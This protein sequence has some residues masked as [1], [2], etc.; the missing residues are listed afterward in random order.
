MALKV[1]KGQTSSLVESTRWYPESGLILQRPDDPAGGVGRLILSAGDLAW[2]AQCQHRT[3]MDKA[4]MEGAQFSRAEIDPFAAM[5]AAAGDAHEQAYL[6]HLQATLG[7]EQVVDCSG[8]NFEDQCETTKAAIQ[9]KAPVLF[10]AALLT[11]DP[12]IDGVWW[13]GH[14]DFAMRTDEGAYEPYDTKYGANVKE[15]WVVQL[16]VYAHQLAQNTS[17]DPRRAVVVSPGID[18]GFELQEVEVRRNVMAGLRRELIEKVMSD[19]GG[20]TRPDR[21]GACTACTWQS[22]CDDQRRHQRNLTLV[23]GI[24]SNQVAALRNAGINTIDDLADTDANGAGPPVLE[25]V[26]EMVALRLARQAAA[27]IAT[28]GTGQMFVEV[29]DTGPS[30]LGAMPPPSPGDLY[31]DIEGSPLIEG[32]LEYLFGVGWLESDHFVFKP[33]W[34]T[35]PDAERQAFDE[36]I[37]LFTDQLRSRPGSHIYHYNHYERTALRRLS[38]RHDLHAGVV[39]ELI[40]PALVDLL[41]VVRRSLIVGAEGMGLKKLEPLFRPKRAGDV[42]DAVSSIV[43]FQRFVETGDQDILKS[44]E[45]YNRDDVES[46][47]LLHEWLLNQRSA[48]S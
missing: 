45:E 33:L 32:G 18:D 19:V 37:G 9:A 26:S 4:V 42:T 48:L 25:G 2:F 30:G 41:P 3:T 40:E 23:Y 34:A 28:E 24:R 11:P 21:K 20:E 38:E 39:E 10:Q 8:G 22:L 44:L 15:S 16:S 6:R 14:V 13:R 29:I 17:V 36:L 1:C 46:T 7:A 31:F 47:W 43:E 12:E 35:S 5:L 27:Q